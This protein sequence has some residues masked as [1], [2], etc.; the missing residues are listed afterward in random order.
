MTSAE[1]KI[2]LVT[3]AAR[4][5]GAV[6]ARRFAGA[7][8]TVVIHAFQSAAAARE[9]VSD[10]PGG[11]ARHRVVTADLA[12]PAGAEALFAALEGTA[13][14]I[15]VNNAALYSRRGLFESSPEEYRRFMQVNFL[16]PL[17]LMRLF[18]ASST[19]SGR[20]VV[21]ILDA[22]AGDPPL[23]AYSLSKRALRDATI[24]AAAVLGREYGIRVNGVAPGPVL[25][26]DGVAHPLRESRLVSVLGR[27]PEPEE[28]AEAVCFAALH[29]ALTGVIL[30]VDAGFRLGKERRR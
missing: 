18:A 24:E 20:S 19:R 12:D 1:G 3:G 16:S 5:L 11:A 27:T 6:I 26:P 13:P 28:V 10:L 2:V 22:S 15:L 29:P 8:A 25:A 21:N 7:G 30:P 4:R 23:G 17:E 9:V 14:D